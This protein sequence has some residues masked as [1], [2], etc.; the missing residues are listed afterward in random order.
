MA[1]MLVVYKNPL[2]PEAFD[3]HYF[4]IHMP[5]AKKLPG[6]RRYEVS[7]GP[8]HALS[9]GDAPYM[10]ATLHFDSVADIRSAFATEAGAACAAD[11]RKFA[12][13]GS[14]TMLLFDEA[15]V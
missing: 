4:E 14:F 8:I 12:P 5:L 7:K 3:R 2:N 6:L 13:D 9:A 10:V 15:S 1:K 11:R